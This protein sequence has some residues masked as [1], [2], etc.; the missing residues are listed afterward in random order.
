MKEDPLADCKGS[1]LIVDDLPDNLRLLRDTLKGQ[2]YKVRSCTTGAMVLRGAKAAVTDLILLDIKLPDMDGYEICRQLKADEQTA[3]I[4]VIFLS[5]LNNTFDKVQGFTFGGADYITK[6]F[7]VEEV[8][9]RVA[10]H[11]SIVRLQKSLKAQNVQLIQEIE[12][13]KRIEEALFIEKELAQVTLKSI[14]DAVITTDA[15]G[16]ISYINPV[17]EALT[18]WSH[19]DAQGLPLFEVFYIVNEESNKPVENPATKALDEVRIV[20]L[21]KNTLLI[22]RDGRQYPIDD[23]AAPIQ[24][25]QG[26]VIGAVI[27]FRDITESRSLTRQL[28]WQASHDSLTGLINRLGFEQQLEAAIKSAKNEHQHHVLC[29]LDLDQ[30]KVVNDT[31]GHAAGDELLREVTSLLQQRVRSSDILAR[32]G[33]DEFAVLLN[34]C[35]LEKATEIAET[36]R[37]LI[38][39]FR[40]SWN[41]KSFSIGVSIGVVAIDYTSKD[42]NSVLSVADAA[43]YAAKGKGRN[44]VQVY[45]ADDHE[46][47]RQ[48][49]ERQWVVQINQALEENR[50][51]LYYQKIAPI[52]S[53]VK[54][55]YYEIL[56]R[57]LNEQGNIVSPGIFIPAAERYGLMPAIDRWVISTFFQ[58]Y[59]QFYEQHLGKIDF[60]QKLYGIN[61]SGASINNEHFLDFLKEQFNQFNVPY[62]T[63]CF[64]ITETTAIANFQQAIH[65]INELKKLGCCFAIDDFGHGMNSFDYLKNFPVDYLKIDGSFVKNLVNSSI[66][67]A[68]V[69]SFN[70]IGHVMNLKTIAEFVENIAILEKVQAIGLDYAQG[71]EIARPSPFEFENTHYD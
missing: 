4:P 60:S 41:N 1:I 56:L 38:D 25:S 45:Q 44:C 8:L 34:Q 22:A 57:L 29:Y 20:N 18:G 19:Q 15:Q 43:C 58:K 68:I 47:L 10:T 31:C 16:N 40:F 52:N 6:P 35:S 12:E 14:G 3:S 13:R 36:F 37:Q 62:H 7:Q 69:E 53:L 50:F 71:Y 23:S 61:L 21:A 64:E 67:I 46:L 28:S 11:L 51:C 2:G 54:P 26:R 70:R 42:K 24:D 66:D 49:R 33:G 48:R 5:A 59:Q 27:V 39:K 63:I 55:V 30:F 9:A 65:L 32:L 17:A